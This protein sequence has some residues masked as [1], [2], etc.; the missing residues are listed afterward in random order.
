MIRLRVIA[1]IVV[2]AV[3][4]IV[5]YVSKHDKPPGGYLAAPPRVTPS[6]TFHSYRSLEWHQ[7]FDTR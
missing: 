7:A 1:G 2:V 4:L 5:V 3:A 6:V